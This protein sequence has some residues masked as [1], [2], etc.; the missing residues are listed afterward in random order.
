MRVRNRPQT[1][2]QSKKSRNSVRFKCQKVNLSD[3]EVRTFVK[4][5]KSKTEMV[6]N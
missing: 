6:N 4:V 5:K 3:I 2:S 1:R